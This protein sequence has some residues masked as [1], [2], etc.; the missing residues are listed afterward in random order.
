MQGLLG[1]SVFAAEHVFVLILHE[2]DLV[3]ELSY[4]Q[5]L[6][7]HL[8]LRVKQ[9]LVEGLLLTFELINSIDIV[10]QIC[11]LVLKFVLPF[12]PH[13]LYVS[14]D[15]ALFE[16]S[17]LLKISD[18]C[19]KSLF[20]SLCVLENLLEVLLSFSMSLKSGIVLI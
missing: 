4:L 3:V 14:F 11:L 10:L 16:L 9:L 20:L 15:C 19:C 7:P 13:P 6:L 8:L 12:R 18:I 2:R 5:S 1:F 17:L